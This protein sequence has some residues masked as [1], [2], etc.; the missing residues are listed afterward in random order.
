MKYRVYL[1]GVLPCG[2]KTC[3]ILDDIPVHVDIMVP[4]DTTAKEYDDTL[5]GQLTTKNI[6]FT[7]IGDIKRFRLHGF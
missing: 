7:G 5:R 6:S 4:N 1:F 2:S 3:V